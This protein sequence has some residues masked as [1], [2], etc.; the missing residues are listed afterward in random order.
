MTHRKGR[1][2]QSQGGKDWTPQEVGTLKRLAQ[3]TPAPLIADKLRRTEDAIRSKAQREHISFGRLN[4]S[5]YDRK[6]K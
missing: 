6:K 1:P 5:P 2:G 4:R 3:T